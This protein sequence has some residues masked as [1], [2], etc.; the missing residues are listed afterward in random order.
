MR[1]PNARAYAGTQW[2]GLKSPVSFAKSSPAF[3]PSR[4][5]YY[6]RASGGPRLPH[7]GVP[8][9]IVAA[10]ADPMVTPAQ[11]RPWLAEASDAVEVAWSRRG[12]HVAFPNDLDLGFGDVG[13]L[14]PQLVKWLLRAA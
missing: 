10:E 6:A 5:D 14:E 2:T 8:T 13:P 9:L 3:G 11:L 1:K 12:G 7:V 4:D